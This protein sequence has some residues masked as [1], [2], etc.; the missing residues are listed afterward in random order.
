VLLS[1]SNVNINYAVELVKFLAFLSLECDSFDI[2]YTTCV[3]KLS[4]DRNVFMA[5]LFIDDY[6][7]PLM[8]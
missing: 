7:H 4:M 8:L 1:F 2:K 6:S 3:V 5:P